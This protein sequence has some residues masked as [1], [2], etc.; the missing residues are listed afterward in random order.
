VLVEKFEFT[1]Q[2]AKITARVFARLSVVVAPRKIEKICRDPFDDHILA[3][4]K[5]GRAGYIVTADKDLLV[6]GKYKETSIITATEL[7]AL[8]ASRS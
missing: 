5:A 8:L 2:K 7:R 3:A 1:R 4:A 6:L